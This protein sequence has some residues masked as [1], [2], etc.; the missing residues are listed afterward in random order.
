M[1][2]T[3]KWNSPHDWLSDKA[4]DWS[5]GR[6]YQELCTLAARHDADTLQDEY[7]DEMDQDGYFEEVDP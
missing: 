5:K 2:A 7:Q 1:N 4:K 3:Y 6:L